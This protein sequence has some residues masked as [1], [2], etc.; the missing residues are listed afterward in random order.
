MDMRPN[1]DPELGLGPDRAPSQEA[2]HIVEAPT[3]DHIDAPPSVAVDPDL[4]NPI[5][6][7]APQPPAP[8]PAKAVA[9][10]EQQQVLSANIDALRPLVQSGQLKGK[11]MEALVNG[12]GPASAVSE[13]QAVRAINLLSQAASPKPSAP[14]NMVTR[15]GAAVEGDE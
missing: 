9:T 1:L 2:G 3:P 5:R 12:E 7:D 14:A 11:A 4:D 15:H 13:V 8:A 10:I 6:K